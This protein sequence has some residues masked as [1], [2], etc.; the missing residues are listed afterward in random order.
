MEIMSL[1]GGGF[2]PST[3][4]LS[5]SYLIC[6]ALQH[7]ISGLCGRGILIIILPKVEKKQKTIKQTRQIQTNDLPFLHI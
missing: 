6:E 3:D 7:P 4:L 2:K 1:G 5:I